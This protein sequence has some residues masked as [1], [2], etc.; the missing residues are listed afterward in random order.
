VVPGFEHAKLRNFSMTLGT[1]DSRKIL[2]RYNLTA[3]D[4]K[5]QAQGVEVG[6]KRGGSKPT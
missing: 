2:G 3:E 5:N 4:V 1:R 6:Q